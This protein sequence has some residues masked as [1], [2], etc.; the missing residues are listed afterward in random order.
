[1]SAADGD[2]LALSLQALAGEIR[3]RRVSPLEAA[4][5]C[6]RRIAERDPELN[7]FLTV[8]AEAALAQSRELTAE[9]AAGRCRGPLHGV[10]LALKDLFLTAGVRTT[11]GSAILRDW[12][13]D[14]DA[15]VVR[16]LRAAGA[17]FLG[18]LNM[19]EFAFGI[20]SENP[21][22]GASRNPHD[23]ERITGGSSGGSAAAVAAGLCYGSFGTDTAGSIRCPAALCGVVGLKPTYGRVSRDGV[24]PLSWSMDH[25][26]PL[27]RTVAD[28][29][30]LLET[31]A[32]PDPADPTSARRAVPLYA[33]ALE[34]GVKG[35][36]LGVPREHFWHPIDPAVEARVRAA[37]GALEG[38]GALV[39]EVS[40]PC[41]EYAW[42]AYSLVKDAEA[43]AYHRP[44]LRT[45]AADY[46]RDVRL[47]LLAAQ[48]LNG[49]DVVDGRRAQRLAT[50]EFLACLE[51]VDALLA[52]AVPITAP[53]IGQA[54][55]EV[56]GVTGP[57]R[58]F[59]LR[60]TFPFN[61]T[62]LPAVTVPC[63]LANGLPVGLQIAGRPWEEVLVLRIARAWERAGV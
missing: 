16:R 13:P 27:A 38:D 54:E 30:L 35:M 45:R 49:A 61:F 10:P 32:G 2:L 42:A 1:V 21:H 20:T 37:I 31:V 14:R 43:A 33:R 57:P 53:R 59:L 29:A 6:L 60:N 3:A 50:R 56:A 44:T 5:A 36:R 48:F 25:V 58:P 55:V 19:H 28:A 24:L 52:P 34:E 8:T 23:P 41:L 22:Y 40:L 46:G 9:L 7:S 63:G 11:A 62:G 18:K 12:V 4:E 15:A 26:G 47:R 17:V 39:E 51:Q